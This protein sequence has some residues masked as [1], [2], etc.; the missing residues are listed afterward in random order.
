MDTGE[1]VQFCGRGG[2]GGCRNAGS[3]VVEIGGGGV[4][5]EGAGAFPARSGSLERLGG[6]GAGGSG[7]ALAAFEYSLNTYKKG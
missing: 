3:W 7:P 5:G 6:E 4:G 2:G 1:T